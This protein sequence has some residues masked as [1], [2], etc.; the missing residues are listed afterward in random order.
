MPA[1]TTHRSAGSPDTNT[2][3]PSKTCLAC[4]GRFAG[5]LATGASEEDGFENNADSLHMSAKQV[6]TYQQLARKSLQRI[7]VRGERPKVVYWAIPMSDAFQR[8]KQRLDRDVAAA[9]K[10][11]DDQPEKLAEKIERLHEDFRS[12]ADRLH[13]LELSTGLRTAVNW[14]YRKAQYAFESS[15]TYKSIPELGSHFAVVQ[16]GRWQDFLIDLGDKLPNEGMMRIRIR[17][18]RAE[19]VENSGHQVYNC[20]SVFG[21]PIREHPLNASARRTLKIEAD[22]GQPEIHQWDIPLGEIQ[23]RNTYRGRV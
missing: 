17:A 14:N 9:K 12:P 13:Y 20:T 22:F 7:T 6:E 3:T 5:D 2:T 16:P 10:K 4:L 18:S 21:Q 8:E 19:G 11:L 23:H 1:A 15:D